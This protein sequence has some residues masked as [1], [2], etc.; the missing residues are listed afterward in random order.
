MSSN[1]MLVPSQ[2][3]WLMFKLQA[4]FSSFPASPFFHSITLDTSQ[5]LIICGKL[6]SVMSLTLLLAESHVEIEKVLATACYV[7]Q[8]AWFPDG[9]HRRQI[10]SLLSHVDCG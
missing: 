8:M 10:L 1:P 4:S 6:S 3:L 7:S 2:F 9:T 5:G